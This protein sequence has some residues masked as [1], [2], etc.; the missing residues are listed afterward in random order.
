MFCSP[1][2]QRMA[3]TMLVLPLPFGPT[4]DV[5]PGPKST[6]MRCGKDLKPWM[7]RRFRNTGYLSLSGYATARSTRP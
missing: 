2:T 7:S 3:S 5:I 6:R 4:T 1:S